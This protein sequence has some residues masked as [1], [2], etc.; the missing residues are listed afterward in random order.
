MTF[1]M[2]VRKRENPECYADVQRYRLRV[3]GEWSWLQD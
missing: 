1:A 3:P 2:Q